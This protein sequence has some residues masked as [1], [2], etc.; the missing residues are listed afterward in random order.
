MLIAIIKKHH[1][2][3]SSV[4]TRL[5]IKGWIFQHLFIEHLFPASMTNVYLPTTSNEWLIVTID[6]VIGNRSNLS[7]DRDKNYP[8]ERQKRRSRMIG[9]HDT[10]GW[11]FGEQT[12]SNTGNQW[13]NQIAR[14][15]FMSRSACVLACLCTLISITRPLYPLA[16]HWAQD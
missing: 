12:L 3:A 6:S 16:I 1:R 7:D 5:T 9:R 11:N 14:W 15:I 13:R 2:D 8:T 10:A 4:G